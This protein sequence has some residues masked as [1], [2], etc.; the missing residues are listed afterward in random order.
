MKKTKILVAIDLSQ[1]S[2][3]ILERAFSFAKRVGAKIDV[4]HIV[5][6]SFFLPK[7]DVAYI[8][9][10]AL[11]TLEERF[12][13]FDADSFHCIAGNTKDDIA[14]VVEVLKVD[15]LIIG[16]SGET[17]F[18]SDNYIGSHTKD[19][20]RTSPVPI[21]VIKNDHDL[22]YERILILSD[23]SLESKLAIETIAKLFANS[24]LIVVNFYM[25]PFENRLNSYGFN[26]QDTISYAQALREESS[27]KLDTFIKTL[28]LKSDVKISARVRKS[29]LNPKLFED[30][31]QDLVFDLVALHTSGSVSFYAMDL[32]ESLNEDVMIFKPSFS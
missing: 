32:L 5:E 8:K 18:L 3:S 27:H 10:N 29:S 17:F 23:L 12:E 9:K 20:V 25:V 26:E 13:G 28:D 19:I 7:K 2:L 16:K 15:L 31:M 11:S 30:E 4:I 24:Q 14:K 6:N 21:I 22:I 1:D